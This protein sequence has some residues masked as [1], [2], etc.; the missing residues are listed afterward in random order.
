MKVSRALMVAAV[1]SSL[2]AIA[3]PTDA[4]EGCDG[5]RDRGGDW[6]TIDLPSE[7]ALTAGIN[8]S[9]KG[10]Y[11]WAIDQFGGGRKIFYSDGWIVYLSS[12]GGCSWTEVFSLDSAPGLCAGVSRDSAMD[13]LL[14]QAQVNAIAIGG[15]G[16]SKSVFIQLEKTFW[17]A[18]LTCVVRSADDGKTWELVADPSEAADSDA[19]IGTGE[20]IVTG[21]KPSVMLTKAGPAPL[22]SLVVTDDLGESWTKTALPGTYHYDNGYGACS[23]LDVNRADP[24]LISMYFPGNADWK[25]GVY[26]S[27]DAGETW[28]LAVSQEESP[29]VA[30]S[31]Y[32][33]DLEAWGRRSQNLAV[34]TFGYVG[35]YHG[36]VWVSNDAG[37]NWHQM[38]FPANNWGMG[39]AASGASD[40]YLFAAG[41]QDIIARYDLRTR[42][43][44]V[45]KSS[46]F[47]T[48]FAGDFQENPRYV[49]G[50]G[51]YVLINPLSGT[52]FLARYTGVGT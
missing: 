35:D 46:P 19:T 48:D 39:C 36:S 44:L 32:P 11:S 13:T 27:T 34:T 18:T 30:I 38:L 37:E 45:I 9:S 33:A 8:L 49:Q 52:P 2:L 24:D 23:W 43:G 41:A 14:P 47:T 22:Q 6:T 7:E 16:Q 21:A 20:L 40:R 51:L 15:S 50:D 28:T 26:G 4:S 17:S 29:W 3:N 25:A 31:E 5:V 10:P 42:K 12:D 1:A